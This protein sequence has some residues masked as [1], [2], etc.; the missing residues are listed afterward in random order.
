VVIAQQNLVNIESQKNSRR[1]PETLCAINLRKKGICMARSIY[2]LKLHQG[3]QVDINDCISC[4]RVP[5]G[6]IYRYP[7]ESMVFV[8]WHNEFQHTNAPD[9]KEGANLQQTTRKVMQ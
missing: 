8:P 3:I 2:S 1:V 6:W 9:A 5:G 7:P 4:I